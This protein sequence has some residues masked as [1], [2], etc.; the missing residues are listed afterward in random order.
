MAIFV[1]AILPGVTTDQYDTLNAKLQETPD[2]FDGCISHACAATDDGLE[3]FDTWESEQQMN[4]FAER[5]MPIAAG[6]GWPEPGG[7]PRVLRV[8]NYWVPGTTG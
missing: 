1:H 8:H 3:V 7:A 2:I 5:M 4:A 6:L